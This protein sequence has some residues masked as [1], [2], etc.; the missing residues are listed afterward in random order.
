MYL[1]WPDR[2]YNNASQDACNKLSKIASRSNCQRRNVQML[3]YATGTIVALTNFITLLPLCLRNPYY[4]YKQHLNSSHTTFIAVNCFH[5]VR[6]HIPPPHTPQDVASLPYYEH[7]VL[8]VFYIN[9][10]P[11]DGRSLGCLLY[12]THGAECLALSAKFVRLRKL[13]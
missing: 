2:Q 5:F 13:I 12:H 7:N 11:S 4:T 8:L 1:L 6:P 3:C 10:P 9:P